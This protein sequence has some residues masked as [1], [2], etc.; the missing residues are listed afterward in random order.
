M[1]SGNARVFI[2]ENVSILAGS[3]SSHCVYSAETM[4]GGLPSAV[5][6]VMVQSQMWPGRVGG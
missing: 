6:E 2:T 1:M 3:P 4:L 5:T